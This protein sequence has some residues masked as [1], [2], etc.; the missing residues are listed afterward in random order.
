LKSFFFLFFFIAIT[1]KLPSVQLP[2][3]RNNKTWHF[4]FCP[5]KGMGSWWKMFAIFHKK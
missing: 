3:L 5:W 1:P 4:F 2:K